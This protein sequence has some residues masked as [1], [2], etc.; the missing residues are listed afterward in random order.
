M[1]HAAGSDHAA[2]LQ[3]AAQVEKGLQ[4]LLHQEMEF[5]L[6][7]D[8]AVAAMMLAAVNGA[9]LGGAGNGDHRVQPDEIRCA[10]QRYSGRSLPGFPRVGA[11]FMDYARKVA[12]DLLT[13]VLEP[14]EKV[15]RCR[16]YEIE[17]KQAVG[18]ECVGWRPED[19]DGNVCGTWMRLGGFIAG[20]VAI[21]A[22]RF[23]L[24][25]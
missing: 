13:L 9:T 8:L 7:S 24:R 20:V 1:R 17:G 4:V 19:P 16:R 10:G 25:C 15:L 12:G 5:H 21:P 6:D 3:A 23:S 14:L 18:L 2:A 22:R 11:A